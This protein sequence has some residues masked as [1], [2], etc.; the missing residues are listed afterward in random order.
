[1]KSIWA[2]SILIPICVALVVGVCIVAVGEIYLAL[3]EGAIFLALPLMFII[4]IVAA[5]L[6]KRTETETNSK[7]E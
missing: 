1:M 6:T 2:Q 4:V 3:G 5:L 7:S